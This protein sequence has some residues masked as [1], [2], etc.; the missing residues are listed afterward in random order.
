VSCLTWQAA[1]VPV[2][3]VAPLRN[4]AQR[5]A[6]PEL[7]AITMARLLQVD[8]A[9][10]DLLVHEKRPTPLADAVV[11]V[12]GASNALARLLGADPAAFDTLQDL[13]RRSIGD[14]S[15][16]DQ[17][18]PIAHGQPE[19][20]RGFSHVVR[21]KALELLRIAARDLL[22]LDDLA[23]VGANLAD[24][25]GHVLAAAVRAAGVD[26]LAII[27]MGK[28]GGQ[29]LNYAS[30]IDVVFV[31]TTERAEVDARRVLELARQCFR[32]DTDL[33]PGGRSG[34]LVRTVIGYQSYWSR[35]AKPWERQ[36]LVKARSVAGQPELGRAFEAAAADM[37]WGHPFSADEIAQVRAMKQRT[38]QIALHHRPRTPHHGLD[39]KRGPGGIRDVEFSV[40]L[41]QLV[42]GRFDPAIR[43]A[44]TIPALARLAESGYVADDDAKILTDGYVFLR[45]VEHRVQLVDEQ[46]VHTVPTD[47]RAYRR[48]AL[49]LGYGD[50]AATSASDALT[51]ELHRWQHG[52]R[53]VQQRLYFRPLLEAFA[54]LP[55][56]GTGMRWRPGVGDHP[57]L[58]LE[59]QSQPGTAPSP[60]D[61]LTARAIT[62]RLDAFGFADAERTRGSVVALARGLTRSSRLMSQMLPL[63]LDWLSQSPDPDLGLQQLRDLVSR[64]HQRQVVLSTFRESPEAARR[65]CLLLG[66]GRLFGE[67]LLRSPD[68]IARLGDDDA[69]APL[70]LQAAR[71]VLG[72]RYRPGTTSG[73]YRDHLVRFHRGQLLHTAARDVLGLDDT[74]ATAAALTT[75]A[76]AVLEAAMA[77]VGPDLSWCA[78][79]LGRFAGAELSYASD[80]DLVLVC[81]DG[82]EQR[83]AEAAESLLHLL[84]GEGS[85]NRI[86]R[87]DL[88]LRPEGDQGRLVRDLD[89]YRTYFG[90]WMQTW[91][92]QA[93]ARARLVAGDVTL[94]RQF[95]DLVEELVWQHPFTAQ[96]IAEIR[97]MKARMERERIPAHEDPR[98]HLKLGRG[99]LTDVEWTVQLLQLRH[100]IV[101]PGTMAALDRLESARLLDP[102]DAAS[103]RAAYRFCEHTRNRWYL[104]GAL[105]GAAA[106]GDALP[107]RADRL[108]RLARSLGTTPSALRE[109][110]LRVTRRARSVVERVFYEM[111]ATQRGGGAVDLGP[112][113]R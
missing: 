37:V 84:H 82:E 8:P 75:S 108:S 9:R 96:D 57:Q 99:A 73:E 80:L 66:T 23:T 28:L 64:Q 63:I 86:L 90:R 54:A 11:A 97:R 68:S 47:H 109:Q 107:T 52:V 50:S 38:E 101:E 46:Q 26:S 94:G 42:H 6:A 104:V 32:V 87:I 21:A 15:P 70:P 30:D 65:I 34:P 72:R 91:E 33:R 43:S 74:P 22:G 20:P 49:V 36:A 106:P 41:L 29:E 5:S 98:F 110:F 77:A 61:M 85:F 55:Q 113:K 19:L 44:S 111:P 76:E 17:S 1:G 89:A 48:L 102:R 3:L 88:G 45:T 69:L 71:Q 95:L 92:R 25:A 60:A 56:P 78:L 18:T 27:G 53:A 112:T 67:A 4:L 103:L 93:M 100:G 2:D 35:W 40:Q 24:L 83:G 81:A 51:A 7:C 10:I 79:G 12:T 59:D 31:S 14:D 16:L 58:G 39:I 13:D 62:A 105:A